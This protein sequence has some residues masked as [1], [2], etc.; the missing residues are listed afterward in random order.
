MAIF[1]AF[2]RWVC[3]CWRGTAT[4]MNAWLDWIISPITSSGGAYG[5]WVCDNITIPETSH[6]SS[7]LF[8][9]NGEE[10]QGCLNEKQWRHEHDYTTKNDYFVSLSCCSTLL[11]L[12][13]LWSKPHNVGVTTPQLPPISTEEK[14]HLNLHYLSWPTPVRV[15]RK[16]R[17]W[18]SHLERPL[19]FAWKGNTTIL[20]QSAHV[21]ADPNPSNSSTSNAMRGNMKPSQLKTMLLPANP[22][23]GLLYDPILPLCNIPDLGSG[24]FC[25]DFST[26]IQV[27]RALFFDVTTVWRCI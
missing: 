11:G 19:I 21:S 17:F 22:Q 10:S 4:G 23:R 3:C 8:F 6:I 15:P 5:D 16:E 26:P 14:V 27:R 12:A 1:A 13:F 25:W 2:V 24:C 7:L 20:F 18:I 9:R